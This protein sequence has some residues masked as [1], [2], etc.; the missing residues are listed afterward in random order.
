MNNKHQTQITELS[1]IG[2]QTKDHPSIEDF[3]AHNQLI[4]KL[5]NE[6][7]L[8]EIKINA[9]N[10]ELDVRFSEVVKL[11]RLLLITDRASCCDTKIDEGQL[12]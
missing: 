2:T 12:K 3:T 7:K 10:E 9:L 8:S 11:T 5:K 1:V 6:L 4:A